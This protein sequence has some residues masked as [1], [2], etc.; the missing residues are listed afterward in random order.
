VIAPLAAGET[1]AVELRPFE[2][3]SLSTGLDRADLT[4]TRVTAD[5]PVAV[6][7][8]HEA[9]NAARV[10]RCDPSTGTCVHDPTIACGCDPGEPPSCDPRAPCSA[11]VECCADH[12]EQQMPP[13]STWGDEVLAVR[14]YPRATETDVW[15]I[16][17]SADATTVTLD[18]A[19]AVVPGLDAGEWYE[20]ESD[21]DFVARAS[22]PILVGQFLAGFDAA[23]GSGDPSFILAPPVRQLRSTYRVFATGAYTH[24]YVSIGAADVAIVLIDGLDADAQ[25]FLQG[26]PF[27]GG[28]RSIRLPISGGLHHIDCGGP[29]AVTVYGYSHYASYGYPAGMDLSR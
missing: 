2:V 3:L 4:G 1:L 19:V 22:A 13:V 9:G 28:W 25:P 24:D 14:S 23:G 18:P 16:L 15:R 21:V 6:F 7:A 12:L 17:A 5:R 20:I 10:G 8:G 11:P 29:C 26:G 27:G